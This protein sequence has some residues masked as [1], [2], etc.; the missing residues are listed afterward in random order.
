[1]SST[2]TLKPK[3]HPAI[4]IPLLHWRAADTL[5]GVH[6]A[7]TLPAVAAERKLATILFADIVGSSGVTGSHDPE[8][9]R[10]TLAQVFAA[11]K[12]VL[13]DHGGTVEKFIG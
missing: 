8:V 13:A 3:S 1:M 10:R 2:L 5:D 9:V 4:F 11:M 12:N 7:P 6:S